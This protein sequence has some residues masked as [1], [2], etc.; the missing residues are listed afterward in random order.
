MTFFG[1]IW[2]IL[3]FQPGQSEYLYSSSRSPYFRRC[4]SHIAAETEFLKDFMSVIL[5]DLMLLNSGD[6]TVAWNT[7]LVGRAAV[8]YT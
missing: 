8:D 6:Y 3:L 4:I 7:S 2:C 1:A 5:R